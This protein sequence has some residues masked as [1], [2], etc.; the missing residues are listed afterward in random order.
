MVTTKQKPRADIL[1][2]KKFKHTT[3]E[4]IQPQGKRVKVEW[5]NELEK[6][7]NTIKK[8]TMSLYLLIIAL[9]ILGLNS[10]VKRQ[11]G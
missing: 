1:R 7:E 3:R 10:P 6:R 11:S 4:V 9:T 5:G 8:M 2:R